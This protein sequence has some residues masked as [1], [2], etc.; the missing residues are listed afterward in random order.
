LKLSKNKVGVNMLDKNVIYD[1]LGVAALKDSDFVEIFV[2]ENRHNNLVAV[3]GTIEKAQSGIDYGVGI[4]I[5]RGLDSLFACTN[6]VSK[7]NLVKIVN[8]LN[9]ISENKNKKSLP[10]FKILN[11][12]GLHPVKTHFS[13]L[14]KKRA[15]N[16]LKECCLSALE[17]SPIVREVSGSYIDSTQNILVANTEGVWAEDTRFKTRMLFM[18]VASNGI[19]KQSSVMRNGAHAGFDFYDNLDAKRIGVSAAKSAITVL[20]ADACP[21][22][23]MPVIVGN[24]FGGVVFHEACGHGLEATSVVNNASAFSGLIDEEIASKKITAIDDGTIT[25]AWG[26]TNIDDEG[27]VTKKTLLIENGVLRSY[28]VDKFCG[29]YMKKKSTGSG[30][31]ESYRFPPTSRMTNT[32][33]AA[34][35]DKFSDMVAAVDYGLFAK[36]VEG[37]SVDVSTGMFNFAVSE[38]YMIRNGRIAEPVKGATLIGNGCK[39]LKDIEMVGTQLEFDSGLCGASSGTVA[40][41]CGQPHILIKELLVGGV[42]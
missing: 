15:G 35:N 22:G 29:L 42:K 11:F 20:G 10:G 8:E 41:N 19:E 25:N 27:E 16:L 17:Y 33:I 3:N 6:D 12:D 23:K 5:I 18:A 9:C 34:G 14:T 38:A 39:V 32:Y 28:M 31:R 1:I 37:G 36:K 7:G 26:A 24:G 21:R 30:R 40:V 4:R 2:E 13:H